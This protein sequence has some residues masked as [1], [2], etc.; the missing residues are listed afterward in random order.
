MIERPFVY[1]FYAETHLRRGRTVLRPVVRISV[2]DVALIVDALVDTGSEHVL[3][4]STLAL[5]AGVDM[6]KPVD[7][8][9]IGLGGGIVEA[10]FAT[11]TAWLHPPAGGN[12]EPVAWELDVGFIDNW[13]PLY[14]CILGNVGFLDQFTVTVSRFAQ[15]T[16]IEPVAAFDARFD[17][18]NAP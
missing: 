13:R 2:A 10:R 16:A 9:E 1:P 6:S 3:A 18:P 4:D 7:V 14:P 5:A 11:V 15:A 12:A 17:P 8:E